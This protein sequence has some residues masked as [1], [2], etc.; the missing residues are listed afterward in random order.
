MWLPSVT[1][2]PPAKEPITIEEAR[3]HLR[4]DGAGSDVEIEALIGAAR[5]Y[6]EGYTSLRLITQ[7]VMMRATCYSELEA[8]P[9]GPIQSVTSIAYT[10]NA[11]GAATIA[12]PIYEERLWGAYPGVVLRSGYA[13]PSPLYGSV[14]TVTAVAGFGDDPEDVPDSIRHA[15][16][17]LIGHWF[18]E[19]S[20]VNVGSAANEMP[21][22]VEA[23]L[24]RY[25]RI[26]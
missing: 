10:D 1:T 2:V 3:A 5:D 25:R 26:V 8:F 9:V 17:L 15:I 11:A 22:A 14:L 4:V 19:R 21:F 6:V 18:D 12:A 7:T 23:L 20:A 13:W 16:K 24:S